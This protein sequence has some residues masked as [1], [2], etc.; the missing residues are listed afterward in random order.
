MKKTYK[1]YLHALSIVAVGDGWSKHISFKPDFVD[2]HGNRGCV[3]STEDKE[4]QQAIEKNPKFNAKGMF[5]FFTNDVE[6]PTET[7]ITDDAANPGT[8]EPTP[9]KKR[10]SRK[11]QK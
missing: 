7:V 3:Y 4:L 10:A 2:V 1:S 6:E 9:V 5:S 8:A 11:K